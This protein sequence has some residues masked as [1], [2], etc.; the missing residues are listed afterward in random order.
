MNRDY[1]LKHIAAHKG[2]LKA[3]DSVTYRA[4]VEL[5]GHFKATI[6]GVPVAKNIPSSEMVAGRYVEVAI[7]NPTKPVDGLVVGVWS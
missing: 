2:K 1:L 3:F 7:F 6:S 4:T 5:L